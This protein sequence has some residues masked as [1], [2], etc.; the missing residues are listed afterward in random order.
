MKVLKFG[1]TSVGSAESILKVK[2]IVEAQQEPVIVVVSALG[3]ITD[4]LIG[5]A[6]MAVEGDPLYQKSFWQMCERHEQMVRTIIPAGRDREMLWADVKNLL[7][8]LRSI[9]QG[10]YLI[11]DLSQKTLAAIVSYGER[12]SSSIVTSLVKGS[13]W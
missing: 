6:R 12:I 3:G 7:E 13:Q 10:V 5:T 2:E 8:E 9:Y 11:R 4:Q 1:G